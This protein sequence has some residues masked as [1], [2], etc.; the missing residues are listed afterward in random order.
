MKVAVEV[1][2]PVEEPYFEVHQGNVLSMI[3][4]PSFIEV[5]KQRSG[6]KLMRFKGG[7]LG[8]CTPHTEHWLGSADMEHLTLA[9][10]DAALMAASDD[11]G[12]DVELLPKCQLVDARLGALVAAVNAERLCRPARIAAYLP[13]RTRPRTLAKN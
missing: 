2:G 9:I 6:I 3:L 1:L 12:R 13:R 11:E 7:E 5:G 10:S 4:R 8:L